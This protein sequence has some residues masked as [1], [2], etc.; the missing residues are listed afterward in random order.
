MTNQLYETKLL[1]DQKSDSEKPPVPD[2]HSIQPVKPKDEQ[3]VE[4]EKV[5]PHPLEEYGKSLDVN[6]SD[7][8]KKLIDHEEEELTATSDRHPFSHSVEQVLHIP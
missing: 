6:P 7:M 4:E 1:T 3:R 8:L 2:E 5:T